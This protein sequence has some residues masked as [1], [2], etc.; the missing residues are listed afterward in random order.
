MSKTLNKYVTILNYSG[1]TLHVLPGANSGVFFLRSFTNV[2]GTTVG[3]VIASIV[4]L[5]LI[6][7]WTVQ[8][9]LKTV[10]KKKNKQSLLYWLGVN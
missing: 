2:I 6:S 7:N 8:M 4:L 9:F 3:I 1:K 10:E 5:F